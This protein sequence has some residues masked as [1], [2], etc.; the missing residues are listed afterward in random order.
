MW[1]GKEGKLWID[2]ITL[3]TDG[4]AGVSDVIR[5]PGTPFTVKNAATGQIYEEG[6][7]YAKVEGLKRLSNAQKESLVLDLPE[8]SAIKDGDNLLI[9]FYQPARAGTWQYSTCMSDQ[10]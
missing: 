5:R 2:D 9:S 4:V 7:D 3:E 6:K 8:G 1:G 10:I